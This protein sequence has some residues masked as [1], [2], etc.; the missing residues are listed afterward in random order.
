MRLNNMIVTL[1]G[2]F[3][4]MTTEELNRLKVDSDEWFQKP[5]EE[6]SWE[7]TAKDWLDRWYI[8]ALCAVFYIVLYAYLQRIMNPQSWIQKM[9]GGNN[10]TTQKK[11]WF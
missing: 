2:Q 6:G 8:R 4:P 11:S 5:G 9:M 10:E 7:K 3:S 1:L